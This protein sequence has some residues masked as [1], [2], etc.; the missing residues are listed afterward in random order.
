[1]IL[2]LVQKDG[3]PAFSKSF[4]HR[5]VRYNGKVVGNKTTG[6]GFCPYGIYLSAEALSNRLTCDQTSSLDAMHTFYP[7]SPAVGFTVL[8][9][10]HSLPHCLKH[11]RLH[12]II[13]TPDPPVI[14]P[15]GHVWSRPLDQ[16]QSPS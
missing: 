10:Q 16:I 15:G 4:L 12:Q 11:D 2:V 8:T 7:Y 9:G 5:F 13:Y 14:Y 1:M 3:V 6:S